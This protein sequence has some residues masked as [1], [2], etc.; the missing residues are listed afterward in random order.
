MNTGSALARFTI[1]LS[2]AVTEPVQV[3]WFTS[4]GTA[5]AAVD[6]APAKGTVIFA[7]GETAKTVDILVYGRAV[8]SEDRTF[9]VEMLPPTNAI[10]GASIGECIITVDTSGSTPVTAI[11]VPTGPK[12]EKGDPGE[13]GVSPDPAEIAIEV[14]PLIDVGSTVLTAEGTASQ[15]HPDQTTVKAIARRVAYSAPAKIATVTLADGDN[16]LSNSSLTGEAVNFTASGFS[17]RVWRAGNFITLNWS[18]TPIGELVIKSAVAGDVLYAVEYQTSSVLNSISEIDRQY[19]KATYNKLRSFQKGNTVKAGDALFNEA[20]LTFY[21]WKGTYPAGGKIVPPAST[22]ASS[23]GVSSTAWM[24]VGDAT[25]RARAAKSDGQKII[26]L[27]ASVAELRTIEPETNGQRIT[28]REHTAGTSYG[29]GQ[30]RSILAASTLTD[31]NGTIIKTA[32]GAAWV[33]INSEVINPLMFGAVPRVDSTTPSAHSAIQ[34]SFDAANLAKLGVVDGCG[35]TFNMA[36]ESDINNT[37]SLLFKDINLIVTDTSLTIP[38]IR[39]KNG[40]HTVRNVSIEGSNAANILG[41][42]VESTA[43]NSIVE[44]CK[45]TN[46]GRTAIY[47]T[48]ARVIARNNFTDNCGFAGSGN[49][50][51]SIWFNENEH[52]VMEGNTCLHCTWG[53]IM[54]NEI[55]VTQGYF[56]T[57]RN[58]IVIAKSGITADCQGISASAQ[59][60]L[61]TSGNIVREFPNNGI[62][63]QNCFGMIITG[64]QIVNCSDGVFI[65]DRSCGRIIISD[66]NIEGCNTGVRYYN[67]SSTMFPSQNFADVQ[68]IDNMIYSPKQYGIWVI[69]SGTTS[70]N[71][72]TRVD[73]NIVDG[74]GSG[75]LGIVLDTVTSG[76]VCNN[77]VRR[78]NGHGINLIACTYIRATSNTIIDAGFGT[79]GT[80]SGINLNACGQCNAS[81]NIAIG[82]SMVYAVVIGAGGYNMA[83]TNHARSTSGATAVTISGGTGNVEANNIKS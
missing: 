73:G 66:N 15:S 1:T 7:P 76:S 9:Y 58:N 50:R 14:A 27:C 56:N 32:G 8:G 59:F 12:G 47:S 36:G 19:E 41:I 67:P 54:R 46:I 79:T 6:Y 82:A 20:D 53:I 45:L 62:D 74:N 39:V 63:H 65:G 5:K 40:V 22:P 75:T 21:E 49:Y 2:Q 83:Y 17:P 64:N 16:T 69:M 48:A 34:S 31:N 78:V 29:G 77:Q 71:R 60:H 68:I 11:I 25:L 42:N 70:E 35:L 52:A 10:L 28:L 23:G 72:M 80:Y 30:F 51:A 33:R 37:S 18:V 4:D 38:I 13:D 3:E 61:T 81:D 44:N 43:S 26:G 57:M 55:G 24:P